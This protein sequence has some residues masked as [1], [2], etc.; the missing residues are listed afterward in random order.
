MVNNPHHGVD[1]PVV[2]VEFSVRDTTYPFVGA[3]AAESCTFELAKFLPRGDGRYAEFFNVTGVRPSR[4]V[5]FAAAHETA[6]V[7][8]LDEYDRG[9]FFEFEV[10]EFCP[11]VRLAELGALPRAVSSTDGD[12]R[13][14]AGIPPRCDS[15]ELVE[16]FLEE[17][18]ESNL[19]CKR[20]KDS[21]SPIFTSST[22]HSVL[23]TQLTDRQRELLQAAFEAG[24]Y[25][26]PRECTGEELAETFDISSATF[27][28]HIHAAER[29][30]LCALF[31]GPR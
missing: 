4:I 19:V 28:E 10:D 24:Y 18:A 6:D 8:L 30:L 17:T 26:W 13:I 2:E 22:V 16:T 27:S 1:G 23:R 7:S 31:D 12:G 15:S 3:S 5:G 9:G 25:S 14:V 20:E 29:N 21:I 11:A